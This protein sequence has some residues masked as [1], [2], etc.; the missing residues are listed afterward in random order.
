MGSSKQLASHLRVL[1]VKRMPGHL[2]N[3]LQFTPEN[4]PSLFVLGD[5]E[6]S[7]VGTL[8][9]SPSDSQENEIFSF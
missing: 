4:F 7:A 3:S 2:L 1:L 9:C 8:N 5:N 6:R